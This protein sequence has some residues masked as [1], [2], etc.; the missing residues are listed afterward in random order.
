MKILRTA[1]LGSNFTGSYKMSVFSTITIIA[2]TIIVQSAVKPAVPAEIPQ[3]VEEID[4]SGNDDDKPLD[5]GEE[6]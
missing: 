1:S 6:G 4:D 2:Y 3:K 5:D